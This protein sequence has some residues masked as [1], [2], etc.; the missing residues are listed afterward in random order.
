M[1]C[2]RERE[3][4]NIQLHW[5][6]RAHTMRHNSPCAHLFHSFYLNLKRLAI[7]WWIRNA[8]HIYIYIYSAAYTLQIINTYCDFNLVSVLRSSHQTMC[9]APA[10]T[11]KI[12]YQ[13]VRRIRTFLNLFYY[14]EMRGNILLWTWRI[15]YIQRC[16]VLCSTAIQLKCYKYSIE[17]FVFF[18]IRTTI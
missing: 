13:F 9:R 8:Q 7:V 6:F 4:V 1:K 14:L 3:R 11:F 10:K 5:F 15:K 2:V 18:N 16:E 12:I 17:T